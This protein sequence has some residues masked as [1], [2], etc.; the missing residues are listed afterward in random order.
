M[1]QPY[2][3]IPELAAARIVNALMQHRSTSD[4]AEIADALLSWVLTLVRDCD[5]QTRVDVARG[6][7]VRAVWLGPNEVFD[8]RAV[9]IV[10]EGRSASNWLSARPA[11][12]ADGLPAGNGEPFAPHW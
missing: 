4:R 1:S 2:Q 5:A 8:A 6:L 12:G 10:R 7:F 9:K 11:N 3:E